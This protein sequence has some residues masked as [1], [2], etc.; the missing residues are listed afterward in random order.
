MRLTAYLTVLGFATMTLLLSWWYFRRYAVVRPPI[1]VFNLADVA[2]MITGIV[3]VPLLYLALPNWI[4]AGLLAVGSISA[5][6][7]V[8]EPVLRRPWANRAAAL[9]PVGIAVLLAGHHDPLAYAANNL[10]L[11]LIVIGLSNLWAQSGLRARDAAVLAGA[12]TIYDVAA[13]SL[14]PLMGE[15]FARL[16]GLPLAPIFAW[17]FDAG[18]WLGV[19]L[20]D[21]LL[22]AVFPLVLRKA[23]GQIAG[24]LALAFSLLVFAGLLALPLLGLLRATFPVMVILG[25]LML[26]QYAFW[27]RPRDERMTYQYLMAEPRVGA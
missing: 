19:G 1:G 23:F 26:A 9:L 6:L 10:V 24:Y 21:V 18:Q 25:P 27:Q 12:L 5:L 15:L 2:V 17:P 14:L 7:V 16:A 8:W 11:V 4:V 22:A 20:G 3:L 13:T